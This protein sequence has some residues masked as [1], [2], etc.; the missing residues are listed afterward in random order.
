MHNQP[1]V[2]RIA[3]CTR[4]KLLKSVEIRDFYSSPCINIMM[5]KWQGDLITCALVI[6]MCAAHWERPNIPVTTIG[7]RLEVKLLSLS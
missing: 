6:G 4:K 3:L 5:T 7:F 1:Y 2:G